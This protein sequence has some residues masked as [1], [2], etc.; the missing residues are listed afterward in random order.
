MKAGSAS[1]GTED[2]QQ[3]PGSPESD[4]VNPKTDS[5]RALHP[6]AWIVSL[7]LVGG[8]LAMARSWID[9]AAS[10]ALLA[11][12]A[13]RAERRP[14][15]NEVPF[16]GLALLV[17]LAH[18]VAAGKDF[19][20]A[21]AP[22]AVIA[23]RLLALL[24]LLRW[25]AR[26]ALG[27]IARWL[28]ALKPPARPRFLLLLAESARLTAGLLPL[29]LREAEQ[30]VTALRGRGIRPGRGLR[31][32]ARYLLAWFLPFLGT[33]LRVGDAYA[34]ALTARGYVP[35][36]ARRSGLTLQWGAREW[37]AIAGSACATVWF[38]RGL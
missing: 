11:C 37:G 36:R 25:A 7:A 28:M 23:W 10:A 35:G 26:K 14:A 34:D 1:E 6:L 21:L 30:H 12:L 24:Y 27:T 8:G 15:R 29:A 3:V 20:A 4:D 17:F 13:L 22:A 19:R 18:V 33:M 9:L 32:L 38:L 5:T 31:G 16:L 2:S